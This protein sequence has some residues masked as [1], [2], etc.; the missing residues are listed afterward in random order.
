MEASDGSCE[1]THIPLP[2]ASEIATSKDISVL[3]DQTIHAHEDVLSKRRHRPALLKLLGRLYQI[4]VDDAEQEDGDDSPASPGVDTSNCPEEGRQVVLVGLK[5]KHQVHNGEIGVV[6]KA[7]GEKGKF[8]VTL[9][10][11]RMTEQSE[12]VK[13]KGAEHLVTVAKSGTLLSVGT[14]VAIRGLRNHIE[15]NGC[16]GRIVECQEETHRYEVR[17]TESGQLF[18]V[19]QDNIVPIEFTPQ[20]AS[21]AAAHAKENREPNVNATPRKKESAPG[22]ARGD[23]GVGR[24][25]FADEEAFEPGSVVQLAGLKTAMCYNGQQAEVLS[26]DRSRGRYEI[27]LNDGSVKTVRAEN[28]RLVNPPPKVKKKGLQEGRRSQQ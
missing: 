23:H 3:V 22:S 2:A 15:L 4:N 14:H 5:G 1:V 25:T 24:E 10:P 28:V 26:V 16:L 6:T 27:R 13:V 20:M 18:R 8:E 7:K 19:K 21:A 12:V 11:S 17:A 9:A